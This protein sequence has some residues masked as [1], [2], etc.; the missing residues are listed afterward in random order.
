[1]G[2]SP[3]VSQHVNCYQLIII[4]QIEIVIDVC[5]RAAEADAEYEHDE[6]VE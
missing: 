6:D 4:I 2:L 5:H 3:W 1:M